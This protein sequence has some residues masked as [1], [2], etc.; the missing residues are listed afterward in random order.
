MYCMISPS[1][2]R[3]KNNFYLFREYFV[4]KINLIKCFFFILN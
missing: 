1:D 4:G 2:E 3:L